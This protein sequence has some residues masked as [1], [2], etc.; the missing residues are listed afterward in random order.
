MS[1]HTVTI[2]KKYKIPDLPTLQH[3]S[4]ILSFPNNISREQGSTRV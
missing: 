3:E 2:G 4:S 1:S